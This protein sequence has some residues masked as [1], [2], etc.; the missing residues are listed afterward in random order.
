MSV[1]YTELPRNS[2]TNFRTG[3][4]IVSPLSPISG[5]N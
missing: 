4:R 1:C 5:D 3:G 2:Q